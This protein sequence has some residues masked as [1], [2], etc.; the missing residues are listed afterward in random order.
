MK[1]NANVV[2]IRSSFAATRKANPEATTCAIIRALA[3]K[4]TSA[5]RGEFIAALSN[6]PAPTVSTQF[7]VGRNA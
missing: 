7:Y 1:T 2:Q 3:A 4:L 6:V 5:K